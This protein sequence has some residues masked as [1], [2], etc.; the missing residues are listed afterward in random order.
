MTRVVKTPLPKVQEVSPYIIQKSE[1]ES[2]DLR[3][4][5]SSKKSVR[6]KIKTAS[7]HKK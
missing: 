3:A 5:D 7:Y 2:K 4:I 6:S 1:V